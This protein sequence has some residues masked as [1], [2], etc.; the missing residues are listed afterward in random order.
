VCVRRAVAP[1]E[2]SHVGDRL[3]RMDRDTPGGEQDR[4]LAGAGADLERGVTSVERRERD[5]V[6]DECVRVCRARPVVQVGNLAECQPSL[7]GHCPHMQPSIAV[8]TYYDTRAPEY[9]EWYLGLGVFARRERPGW[10]ED[11]DALVHS[12]ASLRP[13]R[14]LDVACGTGFLT[15]HLRGEVTAFDQSERMLALAGERLPAATLA[16]VFHA[17]RW[18]VGVCSRA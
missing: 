11:L 8:R 14:T 12:I 16:A 2:R 6:V 9:D 13:A 5:D 7:A 15:Q 1:R 10:D 3:E 17:S 4:R 18:F